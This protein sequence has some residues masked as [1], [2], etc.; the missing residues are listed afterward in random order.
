MNTRMLF[1]CFYSQNMGPNPTCPQAS[2]RAWTRAVGRV[3]VEAHFRQHE[4]GPCVINKTLT[5]RLN[6]CQLGSSL[7]Q[8]RH[9]ERNLVITI[10][11]S[12]QNQK[13]LRTI[14]HQPCSLQQSFNHPMAFQSHSWQGEEYLG[15]C[16]FRV[17]ISDLSN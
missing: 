10:P 6:S 11:T 16:P 8:P 15:K 12:V 9:S 2:V 14:L 3:E 13:S 5:K 1:W 17:R 7:L 4:L